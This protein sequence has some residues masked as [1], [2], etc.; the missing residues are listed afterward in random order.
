MNHYDDHAIWYGVE[1]DMYPQAL[2]GTFCD[3]KYHHSHGG[4][5]GS[6]AV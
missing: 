3:Y 5:L 4:P 6:D 2:S 1:S